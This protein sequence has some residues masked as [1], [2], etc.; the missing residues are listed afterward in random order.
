[1]NIAEKPWLCDGF[2][3]LM[4]LI[5]HP[6]LE[7][8]KHQGYITIKTNDESYPL[9][10]VPVIFNKLSPIIVNSDKI[11]LHQKKINLEGTC[12]IWHRDR[13][14]IKMSVISDDHFQTTIQADHETNEYLVSFSFLIS[15]LKTVSFPQTI[16]LKIE[17][18]C[19]MEIPVILSVSQSY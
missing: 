11:I 7:H 15:E 1:M 8:G 19:L 13:V 18:P 9:F 10:N 16:K 4:S 12:N 2:F 14:P 3:C 6:D 5:N 17:S